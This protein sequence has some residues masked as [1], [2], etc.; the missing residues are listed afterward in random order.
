MA[1]N[2]NYTFT[3]AALGIIAPGGAVTYASPNV[4]GVGPF[5]AGEYFIDTGYDDPVAW[6]AGQDLAKLYQARVYGNS[7]T[8]YIAG[9]GASTY[10]NK[11]TFDAVPV[12]SSNFSTLPALGAV[13]Q[14]VFIRVRAFVT[15][16]QFTASGDGYRLNT[17]NWG[18]YLV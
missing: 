18:L 7:G 9:I 5:Y 16:P 8:V 12:W 17:C 3:S 11:W 4:M 6:A 10:T 2:P 1:Q 14:R 13:Q 15:D